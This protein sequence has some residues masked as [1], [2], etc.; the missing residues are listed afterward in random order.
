MPTP[1]DLGIYIR[2]IPHAHVMIIRQAVMNRGQ[3]INVHTFKKLAYHESLH[4]TKPVFI[5]M[6]TSL[7]AMIFIS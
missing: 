7:V 5:P 2:K 6:K 1:S 4:I 3:G